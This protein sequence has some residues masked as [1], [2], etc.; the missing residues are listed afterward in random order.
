MNIIRETGGE[1]KKRKKGCVNES[2]EGKVNELVAEEKKKK[3]S[4]RL[5]WSGLVAWMCQ[6]VSYY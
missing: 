6:C 3:G 1:K 4:V 5:V 2:V